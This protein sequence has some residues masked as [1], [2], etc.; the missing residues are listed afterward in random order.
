MRQTS[1]ISAPTTTWS[2]FIS[3]YTKGVPASLYPLG[4]NLRICVSA[5]FFQFTG[6]EAGMEAPSSAGG[7]ARRPR[8][9]TEPV[10][11]W[12][13]PNVSIIL[14]LRYTFRPLDR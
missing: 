4:E 13:F 2:A 9:R 5:P 8:G 10:C 11:H 6:D 7:A 12:F 1:K 14:W 3:S